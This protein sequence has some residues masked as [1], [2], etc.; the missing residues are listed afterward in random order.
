MLYFI[1]GWKIAASVRRAA[2]HAEGPPIE[3]MSWIQNLDHFDE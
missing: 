2:D 3:R 1:R